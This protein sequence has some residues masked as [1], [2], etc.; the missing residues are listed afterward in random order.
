MEETTVCHEGLNHKEEDG[1]DEKLE[2]SMNSNPSFDDREDNQPSD[3]HEE[4]HPNFPYEDY[5]KHVEVPVSNVF[6]EDLSMP[7]Y[8]ECEYSHLDDAP[9]ATNYNNGLDHQEDEGPKWDV[10]SCFSNS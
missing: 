10:S 9:Q 3:V 4:S 8:D 7:I 1:K 6:K 2:I 5:N